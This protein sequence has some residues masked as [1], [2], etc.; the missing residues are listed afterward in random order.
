MP[1]GFILHRSPMI[2]KIAA[3]GTGDR[4]RRCAGRRRPAPLAALRHLHTAGGRHH[5]GRRH[6]GGARRRAHGARQR[7]PTRDELSLEGTLVPNH[8]VL[9]KLAPSPSEV[10][11]FSDLG[12]RSARARLLRERVA[13]RPLRVSQPVH[14]DRAEHAARPAPV[15]DGRPDAA[16][17]HHAPPGTGR[18]RRSLDGAGASRAVAAAAPRRAPRRV[19][20]RRPEEGGARRLRGAEGREAAQAGHAAEG[21]DGTPARNTAGAR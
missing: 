5:G 6:R 21:G 14:D 20:G 2:A 11:A 15:D 3:H 16:G 4:H 7:R 13:G 10:T 9:A 19:R 18:G 8:E 17:R 12:H 1:S